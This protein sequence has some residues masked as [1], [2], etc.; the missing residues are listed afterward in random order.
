MKRFGAYPMSYITKAIKA[1]KTFLNN[2]QTA[3]ALLALEHYYLGTDSKNRQERTLND[4]LPF[5]L[6]KELGNTFS[7]LSSRDKILLQQHLNKLNFHPKTHALI[8]AL[9][10]IDLE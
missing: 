3:T 8:Y 7:V 2:S 6:P 5:P 4:Y 1:A 10:W 9:G